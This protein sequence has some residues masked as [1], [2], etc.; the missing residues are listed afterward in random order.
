MRMHIWQCW[1]QNSGE[2]HASKCRAGMKK[3][4]NGKGKGQRIHKMVKL[5]AMNITFH[6]LSTCIRHFSLHLFV[7]SFCSFWNAGRRRDFCFVRICERINWIV[8]SP[9]IF[10][11]FLLSFLCIAFRFASSKLLFNRQ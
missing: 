11:S 6:D 4:R 9:F 7:V 2:R 5:Y 8:V 10:S 1:R 3:L